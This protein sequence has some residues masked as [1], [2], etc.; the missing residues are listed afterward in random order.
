MHVHT[1]IC[2]R[3]KEITATNKKAD[4]ERKAMKKDKE[5]TE[6]SVRAIDM[7]IR[8]IEIQLTIVE[9]LHRSNLF[10]N[11]ETPCTSFNYNQRF[12]LEKLQ[13]RVAGE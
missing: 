13:T 10:A 3:A 5:W 4:E 12:A 1:R 9:K 7:A 2:V 11:R 8:I 6:T